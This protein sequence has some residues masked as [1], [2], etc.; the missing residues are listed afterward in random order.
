MGKIGYAWLS[1]EERKKARLEPR[2]KIDGLAWVRK[3]REL[4]RKRKAD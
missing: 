1:R 2:P 4:K 3:R